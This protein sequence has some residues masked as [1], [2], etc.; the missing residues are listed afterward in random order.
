MKTIGADGSRNTPSISSLKNGCITG[1][2][3][4]IGC[5]GGGILA[6]CEQVDTLAGYWLD[7][8]IAY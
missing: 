6:R 2:D 4:G 1:A 3:C 8:V 5:G 7:R